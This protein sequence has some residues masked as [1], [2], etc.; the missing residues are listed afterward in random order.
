MKEKEI[1]RIK[2]NDNTDIIIR[3][4]EFN[5]KIGLTIREYVTTEKYTGFTKAGTRIPLEKM[6][7]F[8]S[9][10]NSIKPEDL[11]EKEQKSLPEEK[12]EKNII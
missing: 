8:K 5:G 9:L 7:E 10:I 4:D 6:D 11:R 1:G 12:E 2:K 3:I